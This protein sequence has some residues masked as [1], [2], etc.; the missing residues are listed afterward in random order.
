MTHN[1]HYQLSPASQNSQPD[2][3][4]KGRKKKPSPNKRINT[5]LGLFGVFALLLGAQLVRHQIFG[6]LPDTQTASAEI[7]AKL[8]PRGAIV[9]TD[10]D[11]LAIERYRYDIAVSPN[12]IRNK[13]KAAAFLGAK[14]SIPVDKVRQILEDNQDRPYVI[15]KTNVPQDVGESIRAMN[16]Y[17]VTAA[18]FPQRFHPEGKMAAHVLGFVSLDNQGFYGLEGYFDNFLLAQTNKIEPLPSPKFKKQSND[19]GKK[20]ALPASPYIPSIAQHDLILTLYRSLQYIAETRLEEGVKKYQADSGVVIIMNPK[21]SAILAM[22]STPSYYPD[23]FA[24]APSGDVFVNPA[25]S[26]IYEPGSVFKLITFASALNDHI[27]TPESIYLD[28]NKFVYYEQ[29]IENWDHKGRG[30]VTAQ[31]ALAESLNV[32]TAKIAVDVGADKF[33]KTVTRFGFGMNT[34]IELANEAAGIVRTPKRSDEWY[35]AYLATNAFGQGISVTP[36]QM[37]NAVAAIAAGGVLHRP[38]IVRMVINGSSIRSKEV[39]SVSRAISPE[40]AKTLTQMMIAAAN[41]TSKATID[42][43]AIAGKTGTAEIPGLGGYKEARTIATFIGF[44]PADDPQFLILVKL[45]RPKASAWASSTAAPLFRKI[46]QDIIHLYG[47]PPDDIRL[48]VSP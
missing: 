39:E 29:R 47:I 27:I 13:Q 40:A 34:G 4:E 46:A 18:I 15:L 9:D 2:E 26:K 7:S 12:I 32:T 41:H 3:K 23:D 30:K 28:T 33:Y 8:R 20:A 11:P 42:G 35:P 16:S 6:M 43:Y 38:H 25:I 17:T 5:L 21:S 44:F 19:A 14:L 1:S 36:L 24:S 10:G 31:Q 22:A 37:A 48:G 45:D